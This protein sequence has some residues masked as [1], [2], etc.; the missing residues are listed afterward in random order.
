MD[1]VVLALMLLLEEDARVRRHALD[2]LSTGFALGWRRRSA[3]L[4][5]RGRVTKGF[6]KVAAHARWWKGTVRH[7]PDARRRRAERVG[8]RRGFSGNVD[9]LGDAAKSGIVA[10]VRRT[11]AEQLARHEQHGPK[12]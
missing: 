10:R 4:V 3:G 7:V 12:R 11:V 2:D 6:A 1:D 5:T 8:G 9:E